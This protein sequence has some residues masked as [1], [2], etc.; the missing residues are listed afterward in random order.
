[1][2]FHIPN[3]NEDGHRDIPEV[4]DVIPHPKRQRGRPWRSLR[5]NLSFFLSA[6]EERKSRDLVG[7]SHPNTNE[8][9]HRDIPEPINQS[10]RDILE[11]IEVADFI[12]VLPERKSRILREYPVGRSC[13]NI[14]SGDLATPSFGNKCV[15]VMSPV[16]QI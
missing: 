16:Q 10:S 11:P 14:L 7:R 13:R 6:Q 4:G 9:G 8:D 15:Y 1:M 2:T 5:A 3:G 12:S